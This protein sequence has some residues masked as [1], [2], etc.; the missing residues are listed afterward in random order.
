MAIY[1][2]IFIATEAEMMAAPLDQHEP[3]RYFPTI[4]AKYITPLYLMTLDAIMAG[5]QD[6]SA[7]VDERRDIWD[8]SVMSAREDGN[9]WV[10]RI[11]DTLVKALASLSSAEVT[12]AARAWDDTE[13]MRASRDREEH[14]A[15]LADYLTRICDL[16]SRAV[17]EDKCMYLWTAL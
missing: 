6:P 5:Y 4:E 17:A 14:V 16:A 11:P 8:Q 12:R 2:D 1:S 7:L 15:W 9:L 13:E 10:E 3:G